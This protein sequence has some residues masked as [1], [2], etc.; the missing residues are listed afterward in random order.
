MLVGCMRVLKTDGSQTT[1]L[2]RD[3]LIEA[4]VAGERFYEDRASG[5]RDDRPGLATCL[6]SLRDGDMVVVWKLDRLG[7]DLYHLVNTVQDP[8]AR[9]IGLKVLTG[10]D[11]AIA[12]T[13][14]A[15]KFAMASMG[16]PDTKVSE[17]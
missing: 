2:Q 12:A 9:R 13:T 7:R 5:R 1:D 15:G 16:N 3:A 10:Q 8:T 17:L 4:G 11:A 14:T 6:K